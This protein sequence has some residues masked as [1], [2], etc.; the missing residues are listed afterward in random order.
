M[1]IDESRLDIISIWSE[2][3]LKIIREYAQA[4]STILTSKSFYHLYIDGFS[5]PGFHI[6]KSTGD[7]IGGSPLNALLVQPP[8]NEYHFVDLDKGKTKILRESAGERPDVF[9][10]EGDCNRVLLNEIL[11]RARYQDYRRALCLLDPYGIHYTWELVREMG[12]M[13]SI[14]LFLNF[15]IMDINRNILVKDKGAISQEKKTKMDLFWG[16]DSWID[17]LY[18]TSPQLSLLS[19]GDIEKQKNEDIIETYRG[20]LINIAGFSYVPDPLPMKNSR[21]VVIYYLVFASHQPVGQKIIEDIF[22]KYG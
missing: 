12:E 19:N 4:Y 20:R 21:N 5:G 8:F 17:E 6:S 15:P 2:I 3:K 18:V 14:D 22:R 10:Y 11:P 9:I 1:D 13:R 7:Y 16:D